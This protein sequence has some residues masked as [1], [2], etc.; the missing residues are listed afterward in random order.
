M[1][2]TPEIKEEA[3]FSWIY[4]DGPKEIIELVEELA[5]AVELFEVETRAVEQA[6]IAELR[7]VH[8]SLVNAFQQVRS[9]SF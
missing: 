5:L 7:D 3:P 4:K 6:R 8:Q 1:K 2:A 9:Y